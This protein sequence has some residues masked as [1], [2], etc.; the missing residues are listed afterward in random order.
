MQV[1]DAAS[2]DLTSGVTVEAWVYPAVA[3]SGW[4]TVVQ[5]Q[6]DSYLLHASSSAGA[7]RPA[8]G[9]TI[10]S[11]VPTVFAPSALPVGV[12]SHLAMTYDGSQV[13]LFVNGV[14]VASRR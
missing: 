11:S 9:V 2:L 10:G 14:Q 6:P 8:G 1:P 7:L 3:Q 13:R 12:W 5:K 4:R